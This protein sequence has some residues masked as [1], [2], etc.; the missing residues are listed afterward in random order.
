MSNISQVAMR[1]PKPLA[2]YRSMLPLRCRTAV[3]QITKTSDMI[4]GR[5][6]TFSRVKVTVLSAT[7]C[8]KNPKD[9]RGPWEQDIERARTGPPGK[10]TGTPKK[11]RLVIRRASDKGLA[12]AAVQDG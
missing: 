3:W 2:R 8:M 12:L 1:K 11:S 5:T 7:S 6:G 4:I 10:K 9:L